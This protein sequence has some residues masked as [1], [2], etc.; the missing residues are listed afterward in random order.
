MK[1]LQILL[2]TIR[3]T[4]DKL[5]TEVLNLLEKHGNKMY[6]W[7]EYNWLKHNSDKYHLLLCNHGEKYQ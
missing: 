6:T 5:I 4:I 1:T 2:M 7:Y 3:H